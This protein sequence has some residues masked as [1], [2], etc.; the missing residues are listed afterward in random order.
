MYLLDAE[1]LAYAERMGE[2][3]CAR[4]GREAGYLGR[5]DKTMGNL[6]KRAWERRRQVDI[7]HGIE[8]KK[9]G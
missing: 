1:R 9:V 7:T 5:K 6:V 4:K 3:T 8:K 2:K